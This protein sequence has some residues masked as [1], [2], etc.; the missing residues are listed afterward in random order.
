MRY[1]RRVASLTRLYNDWV[2]IVT[3][4][5]HRF[6]GTLPAGDIFNFGWHSNSGV[7]I[8]ASQANAVNW[9][10]N[11]WNGIGILGPSLNPSYSTGLEVTG[12][13]TYALDAAAPYHTVAI[14][15]DDLALPGTDVNANLPQ[16]VAVVVTLRTVDPSRSGRGRFYLPAP[17][18]SA[19][20]TNGEMDAGVVNTWMGALQAAWA[21]SNAAGE[22]PVVFSR[23]TGIAKGITR[24][25]IGTLFD[26]Q[27]RRVN[28][29]NTV[30]SFDPMP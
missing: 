5:L 9:I 10:T 16:D 28:K 25:G 11:A 3:I 7:G 21:V 30:R 8:A 2:T 27:Q 19:L 20:A 29:V 1:D 4:Y 18:E 6:N 13:T 17:T 14:A 23:S 22:D 12:C 26:I 24:F 15:Q